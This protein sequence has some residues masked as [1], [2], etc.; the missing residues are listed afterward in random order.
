MGITRIWYNEYMTTL[1][2]PDYPTLTLPD[3]LIDFDFY[4]RNPYRQNESFSLTGRV[5]LATAKITSGQRLELRG[6][7]NFGFI[8]GNQLDSLVAMALVRKPMVLVTNSFTYNVFFDYT[9]NQPVL[10]DKVQLKHA[11]SGTDYYRNVS[12]KFILV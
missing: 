9:D 5:F 1:T 8:Q 12:I 6:G 2:H 7:D 11:N 10:A 3:S 4:K